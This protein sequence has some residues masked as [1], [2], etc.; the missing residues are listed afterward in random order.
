LNQIS[1]EVIINKVEEKPCFRG[2]MAC[3]NQISAEV[4]INKVEEILYS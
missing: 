3:L 4:I 2:D 1:A